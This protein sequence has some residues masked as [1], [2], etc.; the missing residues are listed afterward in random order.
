MGTDF[1]V[2]KK[3]PFYRCLERVLEHKRELFPWLRGKWAN[4]FQ[5]ECEVLHCD[6][7]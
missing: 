7:L 2:A 1:A 6:L 5:A 3:N 4:P